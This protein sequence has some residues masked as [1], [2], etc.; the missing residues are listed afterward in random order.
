MNKSLRCGISMAGLALIL[1]LSGC[2][3]PKRAA[4][5]QPMTV[6]FKW[7]AGGC[8]LSSP[9]PR[10]EV[11]NVP[12]GTA[13]LKVTMA[14]LDAPNFNHGGGIV[15]YK[16]NGTVEAGALAG[17]KGPCPPAGS[18][19]YIFRVSALNGDQSLILGEG[20]AEKSYP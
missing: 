1:V 12:E 7:Q 2:L 6:S 18:H 20:A 8:Q 3:G 11:A 15:E 14:D 5:V 9:N 13:Y 17:Y 19:T 4:N 16:G 10:I